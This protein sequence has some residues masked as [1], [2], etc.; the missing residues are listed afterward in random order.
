MK[1]TSFS[2]LLL[3]AALATQAQ[4]DFKLYF[5]NNVGSVTS[6]RNLTAN[7]S[8]LDWTLISGGSATSGNKTDVQEVVKMFKETRQK[9]RADQK[10]FWKMRDDNLLCFRI[11]DGS[12]KHGVYEA[13]VKSSTHSHQLNVSSYFFVNTDHVTDSIQVLVN[14]I[15]CGPN[16]TLRFKYYV[17]DW[18]D[19]NLLLFKLDSRRQRSGLTYQLE[20]V[21]Q[22][23]DN[24]KKI[25]T[26]YR[27][28]TG[29]SFQSFYIPEDS[30]LTDVFLVSNGQRLRLDQKL[31]RKG[32]NLS[33]KLN[34]LWLN[35]NFTLDKHENRELTIFNMLGSGLFEKFDTLFLKVTGDGG[36][37]TPTSFDP[38]T[39]LPTGFAFNIAEVDGDGKYV[40]SD[41][42]MEY[43]GYDERKGHKILTWGKPCYIEV[44]APGH[45]PAVFKYPG[46]VDPKTK[47]LNKDRTTGTLRLLKGTTT[48]KG[49]DVAS[50]TIYVLQKKDGSTKDVDGKNYQIFTVEEKDLAVMPSS[51][52]QTFIE[53][54]GYQD[55]K[56]LDSKSIDK[57]AE[58]GI[59]YS[60]A[61]DVSASSIT[62]T[63]T[64]EEKG[65]STKHNV[66][67]TTS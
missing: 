17:Y 44:F 27:S 66:N 30:I 3:L 18:N 61:K 20:Y 24:E 15:G 8:Q 5:A 7:N 53:D 49:P 9:N 31:L 28:L 14:K 34:A 19:D 50:Q 21:M 47:I 67:K 11:E 16:D 32:V 1:R 45:C 48:E 55:P 29:K 58:L 64:L 41:V 37:I 51:S 43:V 42:K 62:P 40:K 60:V 63:L 33:R 39:K 6:L 52:S 10:L 46:A 26:G 35:T 12:G 4:V 23:A 22:A 36:N 65:T 25:S 2:L 38:K 54:G 56:M 59:A 13:R 57:Y